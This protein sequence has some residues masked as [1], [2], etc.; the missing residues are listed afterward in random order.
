MRTGWDRDAHQFIVDV[1]PLGCHVSGG[2]GHEDLCAIQCSVFGDRAIVD[3][4]TYGYSDPLWRNYF[5]S[6]A[7]HSTV[8]VDGLGHAEPAGPFG[9]RRRPR[10]VLREW[11]STDAFDLVDAEHNAYAHLPNPVS[12]RRRVIFVK[13]LFWI[14][15]DDLGGDGV[16]TIDLTFQFAPVAVELTTPG[17]C[18][19]V[20][21]RGSVLWVLPL[22]NAALTNTLHR[23][24][25]LPLRGWWSN[26]YGQKQPSP[27]LVCSATSALPMRIITVLYPSRDRSAPPPAVEMTHGGTDTGVRIAGCSVRMDHDGVVVDRS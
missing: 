27:A 21:E 1:G 2:H 4:G 7:A 3:P 15:I 8:T 23:G 22:A 12:H 19:V 9:W 25:E 13:P 18:R 14:V 16:H 6:A 17:S 24:A 11:R 10:A 20:T 26:R 5:R